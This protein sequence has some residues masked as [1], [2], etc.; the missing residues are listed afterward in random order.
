[1]THAQRVSALAIDLTRLHR[2]TVSS[3][4]S[5]LV[6]R[7]TGRAV[8]MGLES[9]LAELEGSRGVCL[10]VLD[11]SQVQVLDY[12]CADEIVAKLL[13]RYAGDDRPAEAYFVARGLQEHHQEAVEAVLER[14]ALLLVGL[15]EAETPLLLGPCNAFE[16]ACWAALANR[17][18][19]HPA[20]IAGDTGLPEETVAP[21]LRRLLAKRVAVEVGAGALCE[22][23][24]LARE[25]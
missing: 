1:M 6:T 17:G 3:F 25:R 16:R 22:I 7:P 10:S 18:E 11:F 9:Q 19:A 20:E 21:T 13:L 4:Y 24:N 5:N 15:D 12:S 2:R 14:H 8:R 23:S